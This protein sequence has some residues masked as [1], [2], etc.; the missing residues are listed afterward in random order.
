MPAIL[1]QLPF[2]ADPT[3]VEVRGQ[4]YRLLADQIV[5]WVSLGPLGLDYPDPRVPRIP[6]VLDTGFTDGFLIHQDQLLRFAGLLPVHLSRLGG[7]MHAHERTI[8][9]RAAKLWLHRNLPG[10]RDEF[11]ASAP[12]TIELPRGIGVCE[13]PDLFPRLPLL[14]SRA[15]R[16]AK[17]RICIG[18]HRSHVTARTPRRF[19][20]F[21]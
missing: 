13:E 6:A 8:P 10:R 7:F 1:R 12:L 4:V 21:G 18:Y 16:T 2:S 15:L 14:G 5:V 9:R 20:F 17:L 11:A 19:W 3:T